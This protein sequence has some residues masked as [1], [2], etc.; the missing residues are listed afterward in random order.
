MK[1]FSTPLSLEK[2]MNKN[3]NSKAE[4]EVIQEP[5]SNISDKNKDRVKEIDFKNPTSP[6]Y[7]RNERILSNTGNTD[8][9]NNM[10]SK[11]ING[12]ETNSI[13]E[14]NYTKYF[15][16]NYKPEGYKF[17]SEENNRV[18]NEN[19]AKNENG[20]DKRTQLLKKHGNIEKVL[21]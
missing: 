18:L 16:S 17:N 9:L 2:K 6:Q 11:E 1:I 7:S 20:E 4:D 21:K 14:R 15:S 12:F 8:N 10:N 3:L 5:R 19:I 13:E